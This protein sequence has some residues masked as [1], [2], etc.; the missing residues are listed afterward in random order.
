MDCLIRRVA[1]LAVSASS[2][3]Q[4]QGGVDHVLWHPTNWYATAAGQ[5]Y[6]Y[7]ITVETTGVLRNVNLGLPR[8]TTVSGMLNH[9][10]NIGG[11]ATLI[12]HGNYIEYRLANP[13]SVGAGWK[14]KITINGLTN[15]PTSKN[16]TFQCTASSTSNTVLANGTSYPVSFA[17]PPAFP[18]AVPYPV[19][20]EACSPAPYTITAENQRPGRSSLATKPV[21]ASAQIEGFTDRV[22]AQCGQTVTLRVRVNDGS[23]TYRAEVFRMGYY[24]GVG[25]R[26]VYGLGTFTATAQPAPYTVPHICLG[27]GTVREAVATNWRPSLQFRVQSDW[28]PGTY[29]IRLTTAA[30]YQALIP[31]VV[32]HDASTSEY[33]VVIGHNTYQAYNTWGGTSLYKNVLSPS[34]SASA[35][36]PAVVASFDRPY[37]DSIDG[38]FAL[39]EYGFVRWAEEKGLDVSYTTDNDLDRL[40]ETLGRHRTLVVLSHAEYWTDRARAAVA[41]AVESGM[42][43]INLGANQFYWRIQQQTGL[44]SALPDRSVYTYR[45]GATGLF[46]DNGQPEQTLL[47]AQYMGGYGSAGDVV[48]SNNWLFTGTGLTAGARIANL[49]YNEVDV[50]ATNYPVPAAL[51]VLSH[52]PLSSYQ[53]QPATGRFHD[54]VFHVKP[55]GARVF[56]AGTQ[57]WC[58]GLLGRASI[59]SSV[60][61]RMTQNVIDQVR[62]DL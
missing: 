10:S 31:F 47:G 6:Y 2:G 38:P 20:D 33:L 23:A 46:R 25:S 13:Y 39:S 54:I 57:G 1:S 5:S 15:P 4:R 9:S 50:V 52:S 56:S 45:S 8:G 36:R 7:E 59:P 43:L 14:L 11:G 27:D 26:L 55:S 29:H 21:T 24:A 49:S 41:A 30:G 44:V 42:N 51:T 3:A 22:S 32:R 60:V 53:N 58:P 18:G 61:R 19:P 28:A 17:Q 16:L 35:A 37:A 48:V 12:N 40:P 62:N 34:V